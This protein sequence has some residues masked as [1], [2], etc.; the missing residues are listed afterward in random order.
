MRT[1][2]LKRLVF[3][4]A[5][6]CPI[7]LAS[8]TIVSEAADAPRAPAYPPP[9]PPL[10][11]YLWTGVYAGVHA[12]GGWA[13]LGVGNTGSGFIGGGQV[14]YNYQINQWV[15]GLEGDI[16]GSGIKNNLLNIGTPF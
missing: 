14:G 13:D 16:A 2:K 7:I 5:M 6:F 8:A 3:A 15:F 11:Y 4:S 1:D 12:G 9:P 10:P